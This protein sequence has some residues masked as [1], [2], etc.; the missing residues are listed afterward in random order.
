MATKRQLIER[1]KMEPWKRIL[2]DITSKVAKWGD[3]RAEICQRAFDQTGLYLIPPEDEPPFDTTKEIFERFANVPYLEEV[4]SGRDLRGCPIVTG[5]FRWDYRDTDFSFVQIGGGF[6]NSLLDNAIFDGSKGEFEFDGDYTNVSFRKV[7]FHATTFKGAFFSGTFR[8]CDFS[9]ATIKKA[10]FLSAGDNVHT[11]IRKTDLRGCCFANAIL[12]YADF[13]GCDL[14]ECDFRNANLSGA[15]VSGAIL[16]KTTDFRGANLAGLFC[17][18]STQA[19]PHEEFF[20]P[21]LDWRIA[22]FDGSTIHD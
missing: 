21:A 5:G 19:T 20:Y 13:R 8:C 4:S 3:L 12:T 2:G 6:E 14:R 7:H 18:D 1:W 10:F 22:N 17:G 11:K 15:T 16:D 9:R